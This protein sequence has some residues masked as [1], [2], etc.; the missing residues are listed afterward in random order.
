MLLSVTLP[1]LF[2]RFPRLSL[3]VPVEELRFRD[4][5]SLIGVSERPV[6]CLP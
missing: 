3:A 6:R 5:R 4:D 2:T 1:A